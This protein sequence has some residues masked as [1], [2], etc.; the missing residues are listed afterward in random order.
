MNVA[1]QNRVRSNLVG[2]PLKL[3]T[4]SGPEGWWLD[5]NVSRLLR[6][7]KGLAKFNHVFQLCF[8][9]LL[10]SPTQPSPKSPTAI[11]EDIPSDLFL[12]ARNATVEI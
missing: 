8:L 11:S 7:T 10:V 4:N 1:Y 9:S 5:Q 12:L 2:T 3:V 6:D